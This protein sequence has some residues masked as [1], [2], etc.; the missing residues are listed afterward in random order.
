MTTPNR[1]L[2]LNL[3]IYPAGHHEAAW[4][5][6]GSAPDRVLDITYYQELSRR[7]EAAKFDAVFFADG[8]ALPDN[9][10]YA[11]RF[12]LEPFTWLSGIAVATE[13]IGLIGTAS[14]TYF[15]PY[16]LARLFA[17]LDH[18][19][20]GRAGWNIVTTGA[21]NAAQNFGLDEHPVHAERY[22]RAHEFVDVV[23]KLWDSWE[24]EALVVDPES[25]VFADTDRIHPIDH[26]GKLFR[27]RGPLN[28]PRSPQGRP[29][30]VQAGS[31]EDGKALAAR[32]AEAIF[33][34]HQTIDSARSFYADIKRRAKAEGR[35][36]D[37]VKV[38]P[39]LSPFIGS[40]E[41]EA[42]RLQ[43]EFNELTQP[44]YG[45]EQL[46]RVLGVDLSGHD[47]DE[48]FPRELIPD[49][50]ELNAGS[51]FQLIVGIIDRERPTIRQLLHRLAGARGHWVTAGTP[52][53][54][55]DRIEEWFTTGAADGFN[56]MP[57]Y[58]TGGF[59]A[60]AEHVVPI[61]QRRGL[62]RT[63]Y[64]GTTLRDHYGLP[65]PRSRFAAPVV[66]APRREP[67]ASAPA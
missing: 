4:R 57:P 46:R 36:P 61:L 55:A 24:D 40:T 22:A 41:A 54:I 32:Y 53:Q 19:S 58:L 52:E 60:F 3:F 33:T 23:T 67:A 48:P 50:P 16:N 10:R 5:Y 26:A 49:D 47:L 34:A 56:V 38:L 18:L 28:I 39:G 21:A 59:D 31:S 45:L 17:S 42:L 66:P 7:A 29:V 15:E 30:Y 65:R 63:E 37:Q 27:V 8:P 11:S 9:I 44:E 51:R 14:T 13:R 20:R 25:G 1:Q 35:D 2:H 62:F 6:P 12:R 64:T 43:R